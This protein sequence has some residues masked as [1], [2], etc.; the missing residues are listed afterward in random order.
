MSDHQ[1]S[2][3]R[4]SRINRNIRIGAG[5]SAAAVLLL[6]LALCGDGS[7]EIETEAVVIITVDLSTTPGFHP[8]SRYAPEDIERLRTQGNVD[9]YVCTDLLA[10]VLV[11]AEIESSVGITT[12]YPWSLHL[13]DAVA[14]CHVCPAT[15]DADLYD[16][17]LAYDLYV[18]LGDDDH[19]RRTAL[20]AGDDHINV[21]LPDIAG[22]NPCQK[23]FLDAHAGA[24]AYDMIMAAIDLWI[25]AGLTDAQIAE[26]LEFAAVAADALNDPELARTLRRVSTRT[27][28]AAGVPI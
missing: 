7:E 5:F 15:G 28:M 6:P 11:L 24:G 19:A 21:I 27:P 22:L 1:N 13:A 20:R 4:A 14:G 23:Q 8:L 26:R 10:K 12:L 18:A 9:P 16:P 17:E 25:R 3:A 2:R